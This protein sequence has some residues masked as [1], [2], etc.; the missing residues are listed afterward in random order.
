MSFLV[1]SHTHSLSFFFLA[2]EMNAQLSMFSIC[3]PAPSFFFF[4]LRKRECL[5]FFF[6][7][8]PKVAFRKTEALLFF[9][10]FLFWLTAVGKLQSSN[11]MSSFYT[12]DAPRLACWRKIV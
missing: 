8:I 11:E 5:C 4:F 6:Y 9:F 1:N 10:F 7:I 3:S 2:C 12:F